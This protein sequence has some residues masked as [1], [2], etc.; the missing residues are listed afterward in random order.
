MQLPFKSLLRFRQVREI[1]PL[2]RSEIYRRISLGTFPAP[3]KLGERVVAWDADEIQSYVR[4]MLGGGA[5]GSSDKAA[6][7]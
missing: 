2:S 7:S 5:S 1:V 6:R 4:E 3:V